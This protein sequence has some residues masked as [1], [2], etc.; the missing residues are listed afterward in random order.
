MTAADVVLA[1]LATLGSV[2]ALVGT[3]LYQLIL[4]QSPTYPAVR[5]QQISVVDEHHQRGVSQPTT[6]RVQVD[7]YRREASGVDALADCQALAAAIHGDGNGPSATGLHGWKGTIGSPPLTVQLIRR[8][9][10]AEGRDPEEIR[11]VRIR[12]E[13]FVTM[14]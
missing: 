12:Q 8:V 14:G 11:T 3:R 4:P 7:A 1:R 9:A 13:Y 6:Y 10:Y 5:V 2:T